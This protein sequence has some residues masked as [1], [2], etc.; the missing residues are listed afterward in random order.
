VLNTA[1]IRQELDDAK[2]RKTNDPLVITPTPDLRPLEG[3]GPGSVDLRLGTWFLTLREARMSHLPTEGEASEWVGKQHYVPFGCAYYL[4]PGSFVLGVTVEWIRMPAHLAGFVVGK[5]S[6]GRRGLVVVTA[7][8]V[9]PG[10]TGCLILELGNMGKVP[11]EIKPG[12]H[13]CQLFVHRVEGDDSPGADWSQFVGQRKPR[14]ASI[15][16]DDVARK[17][18]ARECPS[19]PIG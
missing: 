12:T 15:G 11:I 18:A 8:G 2:G 3:S 7:S 9:H 16:I 17:L 13:I 6:W 5:S 14:M 19:R 1:A 10:F 4:H